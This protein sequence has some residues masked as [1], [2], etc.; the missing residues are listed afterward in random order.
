M[1]CLPSS[2]LR[3]FFSGRA[4]CQPAAPTKARS[5]LI[6]DDTNQ[7]GL[8]GTVD[9]PQ[10]G[11]FVPGQGQTDGVA[12]PVLCPYRM[13]CFGHRRCRTRDRRRSGSHPQGR[14]RLV[15][16]RLGHSSASRARKWRTP[17]LPAGVDLPNSAPPFPQGTCD[18]ITCKDSLVHFPNQHTLTEDVF[19]ALKPVR[20]FIAA[21]WLTCHKVWPNPELAIEFAAKAV[22]CRSWL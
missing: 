16:R 12:D 5:D 11:A 15:H 14:M 13:F 17:T 6:Y 3:I 7:C 19:T 18:L 1:S 4:N 9:M 2:P 8:D 21:G 20:C 10:A 22:I